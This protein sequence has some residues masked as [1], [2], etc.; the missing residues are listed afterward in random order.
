MGTRG[1]SLFALGS[2]VVVFSLVIAGIFGAVQLFDKMQGAHVP[3]GWAYVEYTIDGDLTD[4]QGEA[5]AKS[6][7]FRLHMGRAADAR[8]WVDDN[9]VTVAVPEV[10]QPE[11]ESL[12]DSGP[13]LQFSSV[14]N[15]GKV[16]QGAVVKNEGCHDPPENHA[17][18][19]ARSY[20]YHLAKPF[21][22]GS[23]I[24]S[25]NV[26]EDKAGTGA[27]AVEMNLEGEPKEKLATTTKRM[28]GSSEDG[29]RLAVVYGGI[30]LSAEPVERPVTNGVIQL[31]G[32]SKPEG[33]DL[34]DA[35]AASKYDATLHKGSVRVAE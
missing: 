9:L 35:V 13:K 18:D 15:S 10:E 14:I 7:V 17:C 31:P 33:Q 29:R 1:N 21:L 4:E 6:L 16:G 12:P 22:E 11:L 25:S 32:F 19:R 27:Y 2:T 24:D 26:V 34:A 8:W 28:T 30:V 20:W 5:V 23:D 3:S